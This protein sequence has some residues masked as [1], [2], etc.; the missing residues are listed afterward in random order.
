MSAFRRCGSGRLM[1]ASTTLKSAPVGEMADIGRRPRL[2][3]VEAGHPVASLRSA[4]H[5]CEPMNPAP[6]V[7]ST[8]GRSFLAISIL[9]LA[10]QPAARQASRR[11]CAASPRCAS[12][13][14]ARAADG[15]RG[16]HSFA[17]GLRD[18]QP[19]RLRRVPEDAHD[20]LAVM[21]EQDLDTRPEQVAEARPFVADDRHGTACR[22]EQPHRG[23]PPG[24][25][26]VGAGHVQRVALRAVERRMRCRRQMLLT[27]DVGR[28]A[29]GRRVLRPGDGEA[30]SAAAV[31]AGSH[32]EP[33][34]LRLPVVAVGARD[35]PAP[36]A[37]E[38]PAAGTAARRPS[39][40]VA[41]PSA[42]R[43]RSPDGARSAR[44]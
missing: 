14:A 3:I 6:P 42:R 10:G 28:P 4:S 30:A 33:L 22:L 25:H 20:I 5:R 21:G 7:T 39:S 44:R 24:G 9:S 32:Q 40:R 41:A 1:S 38:S 2:E 17:C 36:S 12:S 37:A 16:Q 35:S 11:C 18:R 19:A 8:L 34:E 15:M 27:V 29:H 26:H 31:C 43:T 23:R 13:S